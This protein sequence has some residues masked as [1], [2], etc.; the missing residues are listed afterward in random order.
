VVLVEDEVELAP[1]DEPL[2]HQD[3]AQRPRSL[4]VRLGPKRRLELSLSQH[5][6]P[7]EEVAQ[8]AATSWA[9]HALRLGRVHGVSP[10]SI[11]RANA[12]TTRI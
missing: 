11:F 2:L 12:V 10:E 1:G 6:L 7:D 9:L 3:L 5:P 8:H 4:A